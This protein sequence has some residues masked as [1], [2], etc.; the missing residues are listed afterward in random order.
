[1]TYNLRRQLNAL[2]K[3]YHGGRGQI[4]KRKN[5][6]QLEWR[7]WLQPSR[8]SREYL[9]LVRWGGLSSIP[10]V[11]VLSPNL[12]EISGGKRSPHEFYSKENTKPCLM[13]NNGSSKDWV[14][15]MLFSESIIPWTQEWLLYWELWLSDG[16][17]RGGGVHPG[18]LTIEQYIAQQKNS[19]HQTS[20]KGKL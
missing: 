8:L 15:S 9:V 16:Q 17:W 20:N 11:E 10:E 18:E 4:I 1:M 13:F 3:R 19:L 12:R 5:G 6:L 7:Q 2:Q 14:P